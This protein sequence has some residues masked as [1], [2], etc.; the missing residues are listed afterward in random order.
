[1]I[2]DLKKNNFNNNKNYDVCIFGAGPAGISLALKLKNKKVLVCE[3]GDELIS[4]ESQDCY[5]GSIKGD[6]YADLDAARLRFFG[7]TSN[8]WGGWCRTFNDFDFNR[9][10]IGDHLVWPISKTEIDPYLNEA[11]SILE[12]PKNN[13]LKFTK[14]ISN[15]Y[16][17]EQIKFKIINSV[18]KRTTLFPKKKDSFFS[19]NKSVDL[20]LNANLKKLNIDQNKIIS[21]DLISY[22]YS[23]KTIYASFFVFAMGGIEN[24]RQLLW[25]QNINNKKLY[26][27]E[28]PVGNY[29]NEH[30]H[31]T[32][33]DIV[34]KKKFIESP[35]FVR[36][37]IESVWYLQLGPM[38]QKKM[39]I[40]SCGLRLEWPGYTA[41]KQIIADLACYAPKLSKE[42]FDL[43]DQNLMCAGRLRAAWEQ[44]P[45][46]ENAIT[47]SIKDKDKFGIPR[48]ILNWKKTEFDRETIKKTVDYFSQYLLEEN[49]GR[50]RL[51]KWIL[52][53]KNYP[54]N[55]EKY[56]YHHMGGTRM[57]KN[58]KFGVVDEN[59]KVYG[60][61][62]LYCA[63][64][65][66][67]TTGGHN[68]PTLPIIQFALRLG[69]YFLKNNKV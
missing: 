36:S 63:G 48:P 65:S 62:N 46:K 5:I 69:D 40:L 25:Q 67:F 47:L 22:N 44:L 59:C 38:M 43:L 49:M 13:D 32:L 33:G 7:G 9:E 8:H 54:E 23:V 21:S 55:D 35:F 53:N 28:L 4:E 61:Q 15:K 10:D 31:Y 52:D 60:S 2:Y 41:A 14:K 42:L 50:L 26:D 34:L 19:E 58:K 56:G 11:E 66:I 64:S 45:V 51:Q 6:E 39:K 30:P 37:K 17:L 27:L 24:S 20:L 1:M 68:N 16:D 57:H 12:L 29:W 18:D 3:G